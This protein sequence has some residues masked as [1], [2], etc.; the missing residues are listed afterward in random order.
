MRTYP[1]IKKIAVSKT[2]LS[3]TILFTTVWSCTSPSEKTGS[4]NLF[5]YYDLFTLEGQDSFKDKKLSY[6]YVAVDS[7]KDSTV[8]T[9]YISENKSFKSIYI[10]RHNWMERTVYD[11]FSTTPS[12]YREFVRN[13]SIITL[14]Y[15]LTDTPRI[16][17]MGIY[18]RGGVL[19]KYG[20]SRFFYSEFTPDEV[21]DYIKNLEDGLLSKV[22][23]KHKPDSIQV[24][25]D[26]KYIKSNDPRYRSTNTFNFEN[27]NESL[28]WWLIFKQRFYLRSL[29]IGLE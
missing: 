15:D 10:K 13:D 21:L 1:L 18:S 12:M 8:I 25:L 7:S 28:E 23:F 6:P 29:Y 5:R 22:V 19:T 26:L 27:E 14:A 3:I 24:L 2:F 4:K 17:S 16:V 20:M 11:T 9:H